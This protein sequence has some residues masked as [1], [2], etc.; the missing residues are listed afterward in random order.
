MFDE[1]LERIKGD[2]EERIF[3]LIS[4]MKWKNTAKFDGALR[5]LKG[6]YIGNA[7]NFI[8]SPKD[9]AGIVV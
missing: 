2:M 8:W 7:S 3:E 6:L 1:A 9:I 5:K 4:L